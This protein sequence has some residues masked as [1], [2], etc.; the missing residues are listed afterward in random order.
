MFTCSSLH[1]YL[2]L[3]C[4]PHW[5]S[6]TVIRLTMYWRPAPPPGCQMWAI[7]PTQ[8]LTLPLPSA[9]QH[10]LFVLLP[11]ISHQ[12]R[13]IFLNVKIFFKKDPLL[14]NTSSSC[15]FISQIFIEKMSWTNCFSSVFLFSFSLYMSPISLLNIPTSTP[16]LQKTNSVKVT[17]MISKLLSPLFNSQSSSYLTY[18]K[19]LT[20]NG[21]FL[22]I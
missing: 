8:E 1:V 11:V 9:L 18:Q 22:L 10:H 16:A 13:N 19:Y 15:H 3:C 20:N 7:L 12:H 14:I 21:Y 5:P 2:N 4:C 6:F 17:P